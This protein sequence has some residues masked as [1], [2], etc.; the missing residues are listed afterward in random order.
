MDNKREKWKLER[1]LQRSRLACPR[2]QSQVPDREAVTRIYRR[3]TALALTEQQ[4]LY[5][6]LPLLHRRLLRPQHRVDFL[7]RLASIGLFPLAFHALFGRLIL[8]RGE[9]DIEWIVRVV[10]ER[11]DVGSGGAAEEGG[12]ERGGGGDKG[13]AN[14]DSDDDED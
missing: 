8:G 1:T 11:S 13:V 6:L 7:S 14:G 4:H 9:E 5:Q 2:H 3:R 10:R 12:S